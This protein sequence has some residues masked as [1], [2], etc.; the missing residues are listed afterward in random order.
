MA[1][2]QAFP[3]IKPS[4]RSWTPGSQPVKTFSSLSGHEQR[5]LLG[6]EPVGTSLTLA[7]SNLT[8]QVLLQITDHYRLAKGTFE[9][10]D[11]PSAIFAGMTN[12]GGVTPDNQ[13]WRYA[14]SPQV[15]WVAPGI[16]NVSVSL[17]AVRF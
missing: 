4:S 1:S 6:P 7:F 11:L 9:T 14:G 10:F 3:A 5:I 17:I 12:Y 2:V 15:D 8:E 16:G 13:S